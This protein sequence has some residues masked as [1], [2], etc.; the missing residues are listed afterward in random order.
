MCS[1]VPRLVFGFV[2]WFQISKNG[3]KT[4]TSFYFSFFFFFFYLGLQYTTQTSKSYT[5]SCI[6]S[7][8]EFM[9]KQYRYNSK[10]TKKTYLFHVLTHRF[11]SLNLSITLAYS[12]HFQTTVVRIGGRCAFA[13]LTYTGGGSQAKATPAGCALAG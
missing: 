7:R 9:L 12:K 2:A 5:V 10:Q 1:M 4:S 6:R 11:V 13:I 8:I 3:Q